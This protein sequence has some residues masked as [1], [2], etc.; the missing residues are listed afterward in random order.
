MKKKEELTYVKKKRDKNVGYKLLLIKKRNRENHKNT[1]TRKKINENIKKKL[2]NETKLIKK[3][4]K[5]GRWK[6]L[7]THTHNRH[8]KVD[9]NY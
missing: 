6:Y 7:H 5:F 9:E 4:R 3:W 1:H 2:I 8:R